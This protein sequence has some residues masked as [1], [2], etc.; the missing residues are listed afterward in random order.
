MNKIR[1]YVF[2]LIAV[3]VFCSENFAQSSPYTRIGIGD[4]L[5]ANSARKLGM[6]QIAVS[7]AEE[8]FISYYNPA[9]LFNLKRTRIEFNFYYNGSFLSN[10]NLSSYTGKG[11]FAGFM[12]AFPVSSRYGIGTV[13]GLVPYSKV[14]YDI[15]NSIQS[16]D[17]NYQTSYEGNG[18]LSKLFVGASYKL[19]FDL[20]IGAT[21]DYYFGNV[22]Y[23]S[24]INFIDATNTD[25][26]YNNEYRP[27][28]IGTT[29]G[30]I[31]PGIDSLFGLHGIKNFRIGLAYNYIPVLKTDTVLTSFSTLGTD[32]VGQG[33]V[34]MKIP[35]RLTAG[36]SFVLNNKYLLSFD[37]AF[38][39]WENYSF[40]NQ[41]FSDLR[42]SSKF[43]LG[44]EFTPSLKPG[45]TFWEQII[46]RAGLSYEQT[47]YLING[48][49]I[50]Q[51]SVSGGFSIP[52]SQANTLDLG[53]QYAMRGTTEANLFKENTLKL[54]LTFS[55][56]DI[57]FIREEK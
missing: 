1:I 21:M 19:P 40:N 34:D 53:L 8:N 12:I 44:F 32:T 56:G 38:Q 16:P 39:P 49:G 52:I 45:S 43:S 41:A 25:A 27:K 46:W 26:Q 13:A 50:N 15:R 57:W 55:L 18:G 4:V 14:D 48:K 5:Y 24:S 35:G 36:L 10:D 2:S 29:L 6:G 22:N 28:G 30:L 20:V 17:G 11:E 37:Y 54:Y 51:Y 33:I 31:S 47:Q 7:D 42:N 3:T 9:G 23:N